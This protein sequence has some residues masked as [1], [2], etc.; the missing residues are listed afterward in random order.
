[1]EGIVDK[2]ATLGQV[3]GPLLMVGT[4]LVSIAAGLAM[5]G[6]MGMGKLPIL[7]M[8]LEIIGSST[9]ST[10]TWVNVWT[11]WWWRR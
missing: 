6:Y 10:R 7:G 4:G 9:C 1:M 11:W 5:M 3:A 2:L 8:M